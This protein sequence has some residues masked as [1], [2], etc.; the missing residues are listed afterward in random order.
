MSKTQPRASVWFAFEIDQ[1][2][3][4]VPVDAVT[5]VLPMMAL[6]S[7]PKLPK[8]VSGVMKLGG[9]AIAVIDLR[10]RLGWRSK[11][12]RLDD[13]IILLDTDGRRFGIAVG[14]I[15]GVMSLEGAAGTLGDLVA[16]GV[17]RI[18]GTAVNGTGELVLLCAP[19]TLVT[20]AEYRQV[21][22]AIDGAGNA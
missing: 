4:A 16:D 11:A 5:R 10:R 12:A 13:H 8:F 18:T 7:A 19:S 15:A 9:E 6:G 21:A 3:L 2:L 20:N 1:H 14:G 17:R 22:G